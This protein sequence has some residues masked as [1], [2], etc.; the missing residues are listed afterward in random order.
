MFSV[1]A[2]MKK[3]MWLDKLLPVKI[4]LAFE[5]SLGCPKLS[6]YNRIEPA[7]VVA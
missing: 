6:T 5:K 4:R 1:E 7:F 2:A 3:K